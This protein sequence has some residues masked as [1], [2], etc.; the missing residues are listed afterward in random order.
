MFSNED[1]Y[2]MQKPNQYIPLS[3]KLANS[4]AKIANNEIISSD[5][6]KKYVKYARHTIFP[7]LSKEACEIL[8]EFYITLREN[9][10]GVNQ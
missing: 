9:T 1:D 2:G 4:M 5:L 7:K 8:K 10:A 3:K 6:L